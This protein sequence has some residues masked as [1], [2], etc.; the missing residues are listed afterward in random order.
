MCVHTRVYVRYIA[1]VC[2]SFGR[3]LNAK[4]LT[5]PDKRDIKELSAPFETELRVLFIL[6]CPLIKNRFL[7]F[8]F[9]FF[10]SLLLLFFFL[11]FYLIIFLFSG[12]PAREK[13]AAPR[14]RRRSPRFAFFPPVISRVA[15]LPTYTH[16]RTHTYT[17]RAHI[18]THVSWCLLIYFGYLCFANTRFLQCVD[19]LYCFKHCC[20][21]FYF[22][23]LLNKLVRKTNISS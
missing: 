17:T 18:C 5:T 14:T 3:S 6:F 22:F 13:D 10:F 21:F 19:I 2:I 7:L 23:L 15:H 4:D 12:A 8:S 16:A 1:L 20:V 11:L 9:F